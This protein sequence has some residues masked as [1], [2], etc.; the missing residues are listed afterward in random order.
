MQEDDGTFVNRIDSYGAADRLGRGRNAAFVDFNHDRYPDLFVGN[1]YPRED[2]K[3]TPNRFFINIGGTRYAERAIPELT[4]ENGSL[5][6]RAADVDGDG[7]EDLLVCGSRGLILYRNDRG[8]TF[9]DA[10]ASV[11]VAGLWNDV[12]PADMNRDG[13]VD[14]VQLGRGTFRIVLQETDG[15]F[16]GVG[17]ATV[18]S[19]GLTL[20]MGDANGD[21]E[22]DFY[23]L[24]TAKEPDVL[25]LGQPDG[26]FAPASIPQSP[27]GVG[28][29]VEPLDYNGDG[30][31]DFVVLNTR[32]PETTGRTLLITLS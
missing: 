31:T 20:A 1:L 18:V 4:A 9:V 24:Q 29:D 3:A 17:Y 23:V 28:D 13:R 21:G 15:R 7:W 19:N 22:R 30:L 32:W 2:K 26:S 6:A 12:I 11:G 27:A 8:R 14:L 10:S 25:L 16:S 5:C